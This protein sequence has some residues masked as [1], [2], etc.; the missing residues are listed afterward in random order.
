MIVTVT[1]N[2]A[3]DEEFVVSDF[4]PGGWF[5][6]T[7]ADRTPGG[8]GINVSIMLR[9]LG[10]ESTTMGYLAGF[11]GSYILDSLRR[12]RIT[13]SFIHVRGETR[14]NVYIIDGNGNVGTGLSEPGPDVPE[15]AQERFMRMYERMLQRARLIVIGGSLPPGTKTGVYAELIRKARALG[16]PTIID[17]AGEPLLEALDAGPTIAKI[18]HRF[19]SR[20]LGVPLNSLDN[21]I[22]VL[23]TLHKKGIQW[24]VASYHVFGNVF[25]CPDGAFLS[26]ADRRTSVSLFASGDALIAG[27]IA[28]REEKMSSLDSIRFAMACAW[29]T[30]THFEKG[31]SSRNAVEEIIRKVEIEK[32]S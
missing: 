8:K 29:E 20:M 3:V 9:Q 11:N 14:T 16:I 32:L 18:D 4:R 24:A 30:T 12:K 5:R 19:M 28:A 6:S 2:P 31:I 1:L 17:S 26:M 22:D 23:S 27:L 25:F 21:I 13:T 7:Q 15:A 10:Y